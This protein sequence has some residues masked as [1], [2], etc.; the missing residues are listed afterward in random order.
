MIFYEM[1]SWWNR[2]DRFKQKASLAIVKSTPA[3]PAA[4]SEVADSP[5]EAKT[6]SLTIRHL[7][8]ATV[9][10]LRI[11][12]ARHGR[13]WEEEVRPILKEASKADVTSQ[14]LAAS[15]RARLAPLGGVELTL[16]AREPIRAPTFSGDL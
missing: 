4:M 3:P 2:W 11:R 10:R 12:A 9:E 5:K 7:D 8:D 15:I 6:A 13:S 16:P 1:R 14:S